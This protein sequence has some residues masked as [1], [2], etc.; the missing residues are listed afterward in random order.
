MVKSIYVMQL[1]FHASGCFLIFMGLL[2]VC[3]LLCSTR[4][5]VIFF[6]VFLLLVPVFGLLTA[7]F[8]YNAKAGQAAAAGNKAG[9]ASYTASGENCVFAAGA[10]A[11]AIAILGWYIFFSIML[12]SVDFPLVLPG[13]LYTQ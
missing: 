1:T 2:C 7:F 10:V 8:W 11:F 3:F 13:T 6:L 5:N 12:A 9:T 4:T